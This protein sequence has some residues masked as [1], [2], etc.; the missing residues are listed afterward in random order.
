[1]L[2]DYIALFRPVFQA[3]YNKWQNGDNNILTAKYIFP[4]AKDPNLELLKVYIWLL[5]HELSTLTL[6]NKASKV[7]PRAGVKELEQLLDDSLK[8]PL[9]EQAKKI[10][11]K[12]FPYNP[13]FIIPKYLDNWIPPIF[14]RMPEWHKV[15]DRVVNLKCFGN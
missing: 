11:G 12:S 9:T 4:S 3:L 8:A 2:K 5:K 10:I 7:L 14:S 15:G 13:N 1:M 6:S